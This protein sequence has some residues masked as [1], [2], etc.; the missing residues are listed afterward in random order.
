VEV[1]GMLAAL[2]HDLMLAGVASCTAFTSL[3]LL[4]QMMASK[5]SCVLCN[6]LFG[7]SLMFVSCFS[8]SCN[9]DVV[10]LLI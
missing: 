6:L 9:S 7:W 4:F 2:R 3:F 1:D 10:A 5:S 8:A